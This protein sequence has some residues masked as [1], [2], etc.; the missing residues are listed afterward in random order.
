LRSEISSCSSDIPRHQWVANAGQSRFDAP[1]E[2]R[3]APFA[4]THP[5]VFLGTGFIGVCL[6]APGQ[7]LAVVHGSSGGIRPREIARLPTP[8]NNAYG[9]VQSP[10]VMCA[11][12][13]GPAQW[14][15]EFQDTH[16]YP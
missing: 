2:T 13:S 11:P 4:V 12:V 7:V 8:I 5:F 16:V 6:K 9:L 15:S 3:L 1:D 10:R 14:F